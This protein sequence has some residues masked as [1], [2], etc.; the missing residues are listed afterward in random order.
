MKPVIRMKKVLFLCFLALCIVL[1]GCS[2]VKVKQNASASLRF[3]YGDASVD[4]KLSGEE[5]TQLCDIVNGKALHRD[6]PSCGFDE[7]ISFQ[8]DGKTFC[9]VRDDCCIVQDRDSGKYISISQA[10]RDLLERI[11]ENHGGFFPCE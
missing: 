3:H 6:D 10:E 8:I 4:T 9:P 7:S 1:S 2:H 11:F 5:A